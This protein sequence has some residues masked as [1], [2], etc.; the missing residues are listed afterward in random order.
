[1]ANLFITGD[2][3]GFLYDMDYAPCNGTHT[4]VK[5][6]AV[7]HTCTTDGNTEYYWCSNC[8]KYFS[9]AAGT[10]EITD[11]STLVDP[12][13]HSLTHHDAAPG[14]D[15]QTAGTVE[16]WEC[17]V[18]NKKYSDA[19]ATT[20]IDSIVGAYG[21]HTLTKVDAVASTCTTAGSVEYYQCSACGKKFSDAEGTTE[22]TDITVPV[23]I[24]IP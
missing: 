21:P 11:L 22:I 13:S 8:G 19:N 17:S 3:G 18:C 4:I 16:Y 23:K 14:T 9:D 10:T 24:R 6:D 15:C 5:I 7:A 20:E 12:A 1:M 2:K